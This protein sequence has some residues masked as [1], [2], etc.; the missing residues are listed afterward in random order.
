MSACGKR[1]AVL[2][3]TGSIGRDTLEVVR[4][5]GE[6]YRITALAAR[7]NWERL[8]EQAA[9][10]RPACVSLADP[11]AAAR[12]RERLGPEGPE[13]LEG[14]AGAA[15]IAGRDDVDIV[16]AAIMG[17]AGLP[18]VMEA[19]R[20]GKTV[21]LANKEPMVMAGH[22][23]TAL[24]DETGAAILPVD[25]EHSAIFQAMQAGARSE[26]R[27]V[28]I[29]A[30][31]GPFWTFSPDELAHVTPE[32]ALDH[33]T[34]PKMGAKLKV[35]SATLF[36]KALEVIEAHW[37][38][39]LRP[40]QIE[41]VVHRQSIVHAVVEFCDGSAIAQMSFPDMKAPIQYALTYPER[42]ASPARRL[43][44]TQA[45]QLTFEPPDLERFP[46]LRLGFL[47]I[48]QGGAAGAVISAANE[49]AVQEFLA[50]RLRFDQI[51][52]LV[53][54]VLNRYE[55]MPQ[56]TLDQIASADRWARE[57]VRSCLCTSSK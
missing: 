53:E 17:A 44:L 28:I 55:H 40:D 30:S 56:P 27:R 39:D 2:G 20:R 6:P 12:L 32:Q 21:A 22:L 45:G 5:L 41:V 47:A 26:V 14:E 8:A 7:R 31:G 29:T 52:P 1:I 9:E 49:T 3:S 19:L 37:L 34:W 35:D 16:V 24:A 15:A 11:E 36:N 4:S 50:G 33:P 25:S 43:D 42:A 18:S 13:V 46:A 23:L 38:F 51:V 54:T 10:F 48:E 57:E